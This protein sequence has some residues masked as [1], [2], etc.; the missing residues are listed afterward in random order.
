MSAAAKCK[1]R[2]GFGFFEGAD[3]V[4]AVFKPRAFGDFRDGQIGIFQIFFRFGNTFPREILF[5]RYA[6][7]P[8]EFPR[9]IG[10]VD[11][12]LFRKV[13]E[14]QIFGKAFVHLVGCLPQKSG[15]PVARRRGPERQA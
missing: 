9:K 7:M 15:N 6:E 4:T 2:N 12:V 8:T 10:G 5:Q 13:G 3:K 14:G 11:V 1:R